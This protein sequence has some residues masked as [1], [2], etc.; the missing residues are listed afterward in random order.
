M[1]RLIGG[2]CA[3]V[4]PLFLAAP[5][6]AGVTAPAPA[7][8]AAASFWL[9]DTAGNVWSFGGAALHGSLGGMPLHAPIVATTPS[10]TSGGYWMVASD[11]GVFAFGDAPFFGSLGALH[12]NSPI[13][14]M[15]PT[16]DN[17]GYWLVAADGGIFSFGNAQFL[18]STG[19]VRLAK[20]IVGMAATPDGGGYWLVASDGGIFSFGTAKFFGS[21]G[22]APLQQPIVAMTPVSRGDGYW[23]LA[24]DGGVF[25]FGSAGFRGSNASASPEA[26]QRLVPT[27]SGAGYWIVRQNGEIAGFGDATGAPKAQPVLFTPTTPGDRAVLWAFGQ[28]GKPY[29]YG[30][31]GPVGFDCS[32]LTLA[33]WRTAG[34]GFARIANE[35]YN[36]AGGPVDMT[37]LQTGDLVFW[38]TPGDWESVYHTALYV[39]GGMIVEA[40][41]DHVQ[42]NTLRQWGSR[43]LMPNGRRP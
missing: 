4:A 36:T 39:G 6:G 17:G 25:N 7:L 14:G 20:P 37:D 28:L 16:A 32:G 8:P 15:T 31:N 34:T 23:L 27:S 1:R 2:L 42:L 22:G 18:G 38:G 35:Q 13:V 3:L 19:S 26:A 21:T 43:S 30:G 9:T 33:S 41:G 5:A 12:L 10:S 40:T 29:I 24:R 11:G